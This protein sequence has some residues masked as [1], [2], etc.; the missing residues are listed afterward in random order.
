MI[1]WFHRWLNP[2]CEH[3]K[4]ESY[5]KNCET[6]R[7]LLENEKFEKKQLLHYILELTKKPE[8]K[9]PERRPVPQIVP[10]PTTWRM[11]QQVL[12]E[13]DREKAAAMKRRTEEL[14]KETGVS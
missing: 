10:K 12:E 14:E 8:Q 9:E 1:L 5:C 2:H 13:A 3:C 7:S 11:R 4:E 6:L